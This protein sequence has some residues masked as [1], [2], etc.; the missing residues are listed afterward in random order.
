MAIL[1]KASSLACFLIACLF[2]S[3]VIQALPVPGSNTPSGVSSMALAARSPREIPDSDE[4]K[5]LVNGLLEAIGLPSLTKLTHWK[6]TTE[7]QPSHTDD[8]D[9]DSDS[10]NNDDDDDE[11]NTP[12]ETDSDSD[13]HAHAHSFIPDYYKNFKDNWTP[14]IDDGNS[15]TPTV[16]SNGDDLE[17]DEDLD[18]INNGLLSPP[19]STPSKNDDLPKPTEDPK[20]FISS[21]KQRLENVLKAAFDS[22]DEL[23]L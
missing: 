9:K 4:E 13:S 23:T 17:N 6:A 12:A 10:N 11:A 16:D 8:S 3:S 21:L 5:G 1:A 2:F 15:L 18:N 19:A 14:A 20:G 7:P 22:R